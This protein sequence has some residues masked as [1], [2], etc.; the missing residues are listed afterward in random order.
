[1]M[2]ETVHKSLGTK[3]RATG[4]EEKARSS[5]LVRSRGVT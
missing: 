1:M 2:Y 5:N 3:F 4:R